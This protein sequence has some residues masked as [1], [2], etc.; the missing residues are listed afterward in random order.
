[1]ALVTLRRVIAAAT[2]CA[3]TLSGANAALA[4]ITTF[5][6]VL[7]PNGQARTQAQKDADFA[8]CGYR[9]GSYVND[10]WS[11]RIDRCMIAHGWAIG[12]VRLDPWE[13]RE[14]N[15]AL[16]HGYRRYRGW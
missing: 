14:R 11:A 16:R 7:R 6:D 13:L 10:Y 2:L 12:S 15:Y 8:A 4:D 3:A 5:K 1:M 9:K